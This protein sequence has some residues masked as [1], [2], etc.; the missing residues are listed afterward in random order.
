V[1]RVIADVSGDLR[2]N[3][4]RF[5]LI[6]I[7]PEGVTPALRPTLY[8]VRE[9]GGAP[10]STIAHLPVTAGA[11]TQTWYDSLVD[12]ECAADALGD[13]SSARFAVEEHW[14]V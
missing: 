10:N 4:G 5:S 6:E 11:I 13:T 8:N 7:W 14:L 1:S 12:L 2:S 3:H 9:Q